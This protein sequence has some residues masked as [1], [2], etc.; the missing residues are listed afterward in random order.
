VNQATGV[1]LMP[2]VAPAAAAARP[3]QPPVQPASALTRTRDALGHL[4]SYAQ[5]YVGRI[6]PAGQSG[7]AALVAAAIVTTSA[8]IP[9]HHA[10]QSLHSDLL[11]VQQ[12]HAA[13]RA[14][15][16]IARVLSA[17][18]GREQIPGVLGTIYQ[19]AQEA[20]VPL[21]SGRY[22]F[23]AGKAG[24]VARYEVQFP[25]KASYPQIRAFING[26]LSAVPAAN[27]DK[28][29]IERKAVGETIVNAE[30]DFVILVRG[31]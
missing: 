27:L 24:G 28:L 18:P 23:S 3:V 17:L 30:V 1:T 2:S 21:D 8:L 13:L 25:V 22:T 10:I 19:Q 6:G 16:A 31:G 12:P 14:E 20:G 15:N 4:L 11:S 7:A 9:A 29:H 26:T 5:Y